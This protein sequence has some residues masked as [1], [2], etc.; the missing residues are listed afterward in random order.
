MRTQ[1][2]YFSPNSAIAPSFTASSFSMVSQR[3]GSASLI[4]PL[5]RSSTQA[6]SSGESDSPWLKSKRSLSGRTAEPAWWTWVPSRSRSAAW[7][8]WVAV[9]FRMVRKRASRSTSASTVTPT[10]GQVAAVRRLEFEHLIVTDAD[11]VGDYGFPAVPDQLSGVGDLTATLRVERALIELQQGHAAV[12]LERPHPGLRPQVLEADELGVGSVF[13]EVEDALVALA[14]A[15]VGRA[16]RRIEDALVA[17][18][19]AAVRC[20]APGA[21]ALGVHQFFEA[22]VVD[23]ET[24]LADH[25]L[26]QVVREAEGVVELEGVGGRDPGLLLCDRLFDELVEQ[27]RSAVEGPAEA[28]FFRPHPAV[29]PFLLGLELRVRVTHHLDG[30]VGEVG[31]PVA[32]EAEH[33]ALLDRAAHDPAQDVSA[34]FVRRHDA[35]GDQEA[36]AAR[37]VGDD[38]HRAGGRFVFAV[39]EAAPLLGELDQ[40]LEQVGVVDRRDVL[41]H[42]AE[43]FEAHAGVDVLVRQRSEHAVLVLVV[44][45]EDV[46]PVFEET[47]AVVA[48]QVVLGTE[49]DAAV[50]VHLRAGSTGAGRAGLPEVLRARQ[51]HDPLVG[52]ADLLPDLDRLFVGTEAEV[53][54]PAEDGDPDLLRVEAEAVRPTAP[55]RTGSRLP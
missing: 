34:V 31:E 17:F 2:P 39:L 48:G 19:P 4:Q 44:G 24:A 3:T 54:V 18:A 25:L 52:H 45:H 5:T 7:S 23:L 43:A 30:P 22:L 40:R 50:E 28:L 53:F 33:P 38:P 49:L 55:S 15:A 26:G 35:G 13:R 9:W 10:A 20:A 8:R 11:H 29:D 37:M 21:A 51:L 12:L 27:R 32:F 41:E 14:P 46:V 47:I 16:T 6:T 42:R 1:S 36:H